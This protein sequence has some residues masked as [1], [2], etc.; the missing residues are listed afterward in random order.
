[1]SKQSNAD[2]FIS[3]LYKI[4]WDSPLDAQHRKITK[5]LGEWNEPLRNT[6]Q[7]E[8]SHRRSIEHLDK[9]ISRAHKAEA[10]IKDISELPKMGGMA[11]TQWYPVE[12]VQ[13]LIR[14]STT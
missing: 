5:L 11:H 14:M 8:S 3:E 13:K 10:I 12:A 4:G 9:W 6:E 1:M 7:L 2:L